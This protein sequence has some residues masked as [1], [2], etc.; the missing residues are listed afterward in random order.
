MRRR[1]NL[2]SRTSTSSSL[3]LPRTLFILSSHGRSLACFYYYHYYNPHWAG[4]HVRKGGYFFSPANMRERGGKGLSLALSHFLLFAFYFC[5]LLLL[6]FFSRKHNISNYVDTH[7]HHWLWGKKDCFLGL[8][9]FLVVLLD[10]VPADSLV[11]ALLSFAALRNDHYE[12][13][14]KIKKK[15]RSQFFLIAW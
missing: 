15:N 11:Y 6:P 8:L 2:A 13:E 3:L 1:S 4:E 7:T 12:H 9:S 10:L 14:G 5:F